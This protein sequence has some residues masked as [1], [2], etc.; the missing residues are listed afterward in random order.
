MT[1]ERLAEK[2]V[3]FVTDDERYLSISCDLATGLIGMK[4][5]GIDPEKLRPL[6]KSP[7]IC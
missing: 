7:E 6:E 5:N 2:P 4:S 1:R 3:K